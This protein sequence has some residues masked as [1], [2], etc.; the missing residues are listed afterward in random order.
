MELKSRIL[1]CGGREFNNLILFNNSMTTAR[2][3]FDK[4]FIIIQ[5]GAKGADH[6]ALMWAFTNGF[7][8]M[9]VPPNW[10]FYD[11]AA[12][13][14]SNGW[15]LK[16]AMPDLVIAFPGNTGTADMVKRTRAAGIDLWEPK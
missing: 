7:P 3:W 14:I 6:M 9:S 2:Q 4:E 11:K 1:I 13:I 5:G 10:P 12:G 15:M 16:F 8:F